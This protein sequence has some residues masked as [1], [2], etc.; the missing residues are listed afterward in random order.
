MLPEFGGIPLTTLFLPDG[1]LGG[2]VRV[3]RLHK[4]VPPHL[5]T[6]DVT[7]R[8][9][10]HRF[11][12]LSRES[13]LWR[14]HAY[15][16]GFESWTPLPSDPLRVRF[17]RLAIT[18]HGSATLAMQRDA[19]RALRAVLNA[20]HV[21][22]FALIDG[23]GIVL[24]VPFADG[25]SYDLTRVW[26]HAISAEAAAGAPDLF[27]HELGEPPD[28]IR[29]SA[30]SNAPG[31]GSGLPYG[32]RPV[33][34]LPMNV[35]IAWSELDTLL[36]DAID[37]HNAADRLTRDEL[38][39]EIARIGTQHFA[40]L[41][42]AQVPVASELAPLYE[43][44][45]RSDVITVALQILADGKPRTVEEIVAAAIARNLWPASERRKYV[46]A[47][48]KGY[49]EKMTARGLRPLLVQDADRRF[50]ANHP[51]DDLPDPKPVVA[52]S[53]PADLIARL[54]ATS[55][56]DDPTAF[57]VAVCD[58]FVALGFAATH[59][60]GT[61]NP[62][63]TLDA[64]LGPLGYRVMLECKSGSKPLVRPDVFEAA[65]FRDQICGA[66]LHD[67]RACV[68]RR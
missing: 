52:W 67:D 62:D 25:P 37:G 27:E 51:A 26:L 29:V 12:A 40:G 1:F 65:K 36:P 3:G 2:E 60:G 63:G 11:L 47:M 68:C 54:A 13:L 55:S 15:A 19:A 17:A 16:I 42:R 57:E 31:H 34:S 56:G 22:A 18:P 30:S 38:A 4:P 50:R 49:V 48:L 20:H 6:I 61:M 28:R 32:L 58:A 14:A 59:I 35:P 5:P 39:T 24:Y 43:V 23:P 7:T 46:Y 33:P 8:S 10:A 44:L 64:M 21:D 53:P 9:G 45:P 41:E 66:V